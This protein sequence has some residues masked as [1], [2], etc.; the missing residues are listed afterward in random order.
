MDT[1]KQVDKAN[2]LRRMHD[3]SSILL[4]LPNAWDAG[5]ARLFACRR[6]N[7]LSRFSQRRRNVDGGL[8]AHAR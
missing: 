3:R 1:Q 5:S 8:T 7:G 2:A 4:L 6:L